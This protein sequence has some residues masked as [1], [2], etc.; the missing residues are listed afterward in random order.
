M[1]LADNAGRETSSTYRELSGILLPLNRAIGEKARPDVRCFI[2]AD[3]ISMHWC[4]K[5]LED[6]EL[7]EI[8]RARVQAGFPELIRLAYIGGGKYRK[9]VS[10]QQKKYFEHEAFASDQTAQE[11]PEVKWY[12]D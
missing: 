9:A 5:W 8:N 6:W 10:F 11:V 12:Q 7:E 4:T 1:S 2:P 3:E